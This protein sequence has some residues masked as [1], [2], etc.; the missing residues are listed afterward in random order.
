MVAD[1]IVETKYDIVD[2]YDLGNVEIFQIGVV[3]KSDDN[4]VLTKMEKIMLS[5]FDSNNVDSFDKNHDDISEDKHFM[6]FYRK[7]PND[8]ILCLSK[9]V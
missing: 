5:F 1:E 6:Y 9:D 2:D 7:L 4:L 3:I 8:Y